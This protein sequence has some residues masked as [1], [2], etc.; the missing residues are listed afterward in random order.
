[1]NDIYVDSSVNTTLG[2][3]YEFVTN[4]LGNSTAEVMRN[5]LRELGNNC[6]AWI[7]SPFIDYSEK[8]D[9]YIK[10]CN[11]SSISLFSRRTKKSIEAAN[12]YNVEYFVPANSGKQ[13]Q[14]E[15]FHSKNYLF[16][17]NTNYCAYVGSSNFTNPG[18]YYGD[19]NIECGFVI[20]GERGD[21]V[22]SAIESWFKTGWKV[23]D[24][25]MQ[26]VKETEP[27]DDDY[28]G[29]DIFLL[30]ELIETNRKKIVRVHYEKT[31]N[32]ELDIPTRLYRKQKNG[33]SHIDC[34]YQNKDTIEVIVNGKKKILPITNSKQFLQGYN[35]SS[36]GIPLFATSGLK[37]ES[38]DYEELEKH[39]K[40]NGISI[41]DI[42]SNIKEPPILEQ[43]Y[44]NLKHEFSYLHRRK[45]FTKREIC[46]FKQRI[47]KT[48]GGPGTFE[49]I[50]MFELFNSEVLD[51]LNKQELNKMI[52]DKVEFEG[53]VS[54]EDF[55]KLIKFRKLDS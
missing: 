10:E 13:R 29:D 41:G 18:F 44:Q 43:Y 14:P 7:A 8:L 51:K 1:L 16:Y 39:I 9:N 55:L 38:T 36:A 25:S 32:V 2:K 26:P 12:R 22:F 54:K 34:E 5:V 53:V 23:Y 19:R 33:E 15:M 24:A 20:R 30:A 46:L 49:L 47:V 42:N 3:A 4:G 40:S 31:D 6:T 35:S 48:K 52:F 37:E 21:K 27:E 17:N 50:K 45:Y 11:F 28:N